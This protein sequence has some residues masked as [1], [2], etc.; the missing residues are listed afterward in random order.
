MEGYRV[1]STPR[2][3]M[4]IYGLWGLFLA[5]LISLAAPWWNATY[6][7]FW[8]QPLGYVSPLRPEWQGAL[9]SLD[10][11]VAYDG[12]PYDTAARFYA[13]VRE[14]A[15]GTPVE[16]VVVREG[17][18]VRL[19]LPTRTFTPAMIGRT[20]GVW[21]VTASVLALAASLVWLYRAGAL[22]ALAFGL[23]VTPMSVTLA[24][25]FDFNTGGLL[26]VPYFLSYPFTAL[27]LWSLA[28]T[29]PQAAVARVRRFGPPLLAVTL[30]LG[31]SLFL[32]PGADVGSLPAESYA[33]C[34]DCY[35]LTDAW[36]AGSAVV[37]VAA[38]AWRCLGRHRSALA[39]WQARL[40][41]GGLLV[42]FVPFILWKLSYGVGT[43]PWVPLDWALA[44]LMLFPLAIAYALLRTRL[45]A[46]TVFGRALLIYGGL[47][48]LGTL[49]YTE[50]AVLMAAALMPVPED[51]RKLVTVALL[52]LLLVP[53]RDGLSRLA[54]RATGHGPTRIGALLTRAAD[55]LA[56]AEHPQDVE[57]ALR[58]AAFEMGAVDAAL[59][60]A[61]P[62]A[63]W[64]AVGAPPER[65]GK[66]PTMTV[67]ERGSQRLWWPLWTGGDCRGVWAIASRP[68]GRPYDDY[69][70]RAFVALAGPAALALAQ[71]DARSE[72][73]KANAVLEAR[74]AERTAD[75]RAAMAELEDAQGRLLENARLQAQQAMIQ[76]VAHALN[77]PLTL[78]RSGVELLE[79]GPAGEQE[80]FG[81]L[82]RGVET[83]EA[84]IAKLLVLTRGAARREEVPDGARPGR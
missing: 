36:L 50:I 5:G 4:L 31:L 69:D 82:R 19:T 62:T 44:M 68:N 76:E 38:I 34:L 43:T 65:L 77:T 27:G 20:L 63:G 3:L 14:K 60:P 72:L 7:G 23:V 81:V 45:F 8:V 48:L 71:I 66:E 18:E 58:L 75:L 55:A 25:Y 37:A 57:R 53:V 9:H 24:L 13:D 74:V 39:R 21:L 80:A 70:M 64:I 12:K 59:L 54:A 16:Y 30:L 84:Q 51:E 10:R 78:A 17:E 41:M 28:L 73:A 61:S 67:D 46:I 11:L 6:P 40:A 22:P 32:T 79:P 35:L 47:V 83:L 52:A 2:R 1:L 56:R 15:P 42:A 33:F 49:F 26:R 29:F